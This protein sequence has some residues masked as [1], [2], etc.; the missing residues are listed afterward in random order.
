M[1]LWIDGFDHYGTNGTQFSTVNLGAY[2]F[3]HAFSGFQIA[4]MPE[5]GGLGFRS[6]TNN[7]TFLTGILRKH[8]PSSYGSGDT[9]GIGM[10]VYFASHD[11]A[12]E[13]TDYG[14]FQVYDVSNS[15]AV[16]T[17]TYTST[18]VVQVR[19]GTNTGTIIATSDTNTLDAA[20][21]FHIEFQFGFHAST[22]TVEMRVNGEEWINETGLNTLGSPS[23]SS[24]GFFIMNSSSGEDID[25]YID[26]LY[27][28]DT[29]GSYNNDWIGEQRVYTVVPTG[30]TATEDWTLSTGSDS[31]ALL[32]EIPA[33]TTDYIEASSVSD[34]TDV[35]LGNLP[36]VNISVKGVQ[37]A[38]VAQKTDAGSGGI[39]VGIV[40][41]SVDDLSS[42]QGLTQSQWLRYFHI[43]EEDPDTTAAF[44][45]AGVNGLD[46]AMVRGS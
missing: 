35:S 11:G 12:N 3:I 33:N 46:L 19:R 26:N 40:S 44:T 29:T 18:G 37:V 43:V 32:D 16:L 9:L 30:D 38:V 7:S 31:Y 27:L 21:L 28:Y 15:A 42:D 20:T 22:G 14:I 34:R 2:D 13:D 17:V 1:L 6:V 45:A 36:S 4:T 24:F 23:P 8:L 39:Q 25:L 41:N 10:H 5:L